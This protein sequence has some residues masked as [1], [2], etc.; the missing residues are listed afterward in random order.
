MVIDSWKPQ[1]KHEIKSVDQIVGGGV[2]WAICNSICHVRP[3]GGGSV[4]GS[5]VQRWLGA[6]VSVVATTFLSW[7]SSRNLE[8][9]KKKIQARELSFNLPFSQHE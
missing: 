5:S 6:D 7:D 3:P 2:C 4:V 1:F 9:K 8:K